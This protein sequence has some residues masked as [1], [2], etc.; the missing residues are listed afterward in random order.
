MFR[1][2]RLDWTITNKYCWMAQL[3]A[4]KEIV[5]IARNKSLL[6]SKINKFDNT[7]SNELADLVRFN[8]KATW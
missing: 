2:E 1:T 8:R 5:L 4:D 3:N 6:M 7:I